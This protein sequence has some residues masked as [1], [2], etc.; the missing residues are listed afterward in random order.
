M[1]KPIWPPK[2]PAALPS[3]CSVAGHISL[4]R[5]RFRSGCSSQSTCTVMPHR[6]GP[7]PV[8]CCSLQSFSSDSSLSVHLRLSCNSTS[9]R[10]HVDIRKDSY[11]ALW[12]EWRPGGVSLKYYYYYIK[13]HQCNY[14]GEKC[15]SLK[16]NAAGWDSWSLNSTSS[17]TADG[18]ICLFC[19]H[20]VWK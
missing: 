2:S 3:D 14:M 5:A 4:T 12:S 18:I 20:Q 15:S 6:H 11:V 7:Q 9:S 19:L 16:T 13:D 8:K 10:R 1:L 17:L